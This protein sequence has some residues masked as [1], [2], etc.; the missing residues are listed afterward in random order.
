MDCMPIPSA[1][2]QAAPVADLARKDLAKADKGMEI[3]KIRKKAEERRIEREKRQREQQELET[4][5]LEE[6][7]VGR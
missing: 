7:A 3:M 6:D 2:E 1:R 5:I 4:G